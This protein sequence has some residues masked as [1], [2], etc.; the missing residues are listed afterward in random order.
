MLLRYDASDNKY[1]INYNTF[2]LLEVTERTS[3][4]NASKNTTLTTVSSVSVVLL[5]LLPDDDKTQTTLL[6]LLRAHTLDN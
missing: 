5:S 3:D 2:L 1:V 6:P 4:V